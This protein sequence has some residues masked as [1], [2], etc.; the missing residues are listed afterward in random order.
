VLALVFSA[1]CFVFVVQA[2]IHRRRAYDVAVLIFWV[3]IASA[4][5][6]H[7]GSN[8]RWAAAGVAALA[9]LLELAWIVAPSLV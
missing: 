1:A 3:G 2:M 4:L 5:T 9:A 6:L 7:V 8:V